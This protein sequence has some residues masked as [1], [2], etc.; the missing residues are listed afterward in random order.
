MTTTGEGVSGVADEPAG[1]APQNQE[2]LVRRPTQTY[3]PPPPAVVAQTGWP[4]APSPPAAAPGPPQPVGY[5]ATTPSATILPPA[6]SPAAP[7]ATAPAAAPAAPL[8]PTVLP[9]VATGV[10]VCPEPLPPPRR[11]G[12]PS[13]SSYSTAD[14]VSSRSIPPRA[15]APV[16]SLA[17]RIAG[18]RTHLSLRRVDPWS[19]FV[20]SLLL[21]LFLAVMTVVAALVLYLVLDALGVPHSINRNVNDVK[22]GGD[23]FTLGRFMGGAALL[24]AANVVFLTLMS[25]VGAVLYNLCATFSGGIDVTLVEGE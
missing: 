7:A 1:A 25:T 3:P 21:T 11:V 22:G 23:V 20:M 4:A 24:A 19:V 2:P 14:D 18:R 10:P 15:P 12:P 6:P 16:A 13:G 5:P 9:S 17:Q 8:L